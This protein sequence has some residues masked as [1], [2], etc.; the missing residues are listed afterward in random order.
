[1]IVLFF[2]VG[3]GGFVQGDWAAFGEVL[4]CQAGE[5][6]GAIEA[7]GFG[8]GVNLLKELFLDG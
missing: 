3:D 2:P 1:M 8:A 5:V 6:L 7:E 4:A